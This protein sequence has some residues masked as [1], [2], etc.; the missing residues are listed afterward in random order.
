MR[1]T[2]TK[3]V[4]CKCQSCKSQCQRCACLGLPKDIEKII[5]AGHGDKIV[6]TDWA[7]GIAMG[8]TNEIIP[9]FQAKLTSGGCVFFKD[10]LCELHDKKLKPTEGKLSHHTIGVTNFK[11][12]KSLS[13]NVAKEWLNPENWEIIK[14]IEEKI[15]AIHSEKFE[16]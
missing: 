16:L 8:I 12:K 1:K 4:E 3:P 11:A 2:G 14:R 15:A 6:R 13:W 5:D 7:A 10:G 9:M